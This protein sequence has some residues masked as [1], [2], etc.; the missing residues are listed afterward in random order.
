MPGMANDQNRFVTWSK[1]HPLIL[2]GICGFVV[3]GL[4]VATVRAG[5]R[6]RPC[7]RHD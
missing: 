2:A 1:S 5:A 7:T 3:A 6:L 4:G